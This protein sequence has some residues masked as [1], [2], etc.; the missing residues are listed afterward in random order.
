MYDDKF[1]YELRRVQFSVPLGPIFFSLLRFIACE[2]ECRSTS[3]LSSFQMKSICKNKVNMRQRTAHHHHH[4]A[5]TRHKQF[6]KKSQGYQLPSKTTSH[7]QFER[8]R[9]FL[10]SIWI[11]PNIYI[12]AFMFNGERARDR[13][14]ATGLA[15]LKYF[16]MEIVVSACFRRIYYSFIY[17]FFVSDL[18]G[19][20]FCF[21]LQIFR[22]R[23]SIHIRPAKLIHALFAFVATSS[24]KKTHQAN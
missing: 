8:E 21:L 9:R 7:T 15:G 24:K 11:E 10:L 4:H 19:F 14:R 12:Y 17:L 20:S 2:C 23:I 16:Y 13:A 18:C 22:L 3:P 6:I 5:R 1:L